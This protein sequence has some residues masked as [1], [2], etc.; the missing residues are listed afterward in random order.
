MNNF[1]QVC[2]DIAKYKKMAQHYEEWT[3]CR[4]LS[5]ETGASTKAVK[6]LKVYSALRDLGLTMIQ[7]GHDDIYSLRLYQEA[8]E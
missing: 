3:K 8:C 4:D 2:A 5:S 6:A 1:E 7:N